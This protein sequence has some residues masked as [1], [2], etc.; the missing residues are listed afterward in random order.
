MTQPNPDGV[1]GTEDVTQSGGPAEDGSGSTG[2]TTGTDTATAQPAGKTYTQA[3]MDAMRARMVAA[4]QNRSKAESA[5]QQLRDKDLPEM[6]KLKRDLEMNATRANEAEQAL[7]EA[8]KENAFFANTKYDWQNPKAALQLLDK[9][10]LDFDADGT[11][12]GMD[13]AIEALAKSDPYLLKPKTEAKEEPKPGTVPGTNGG[14]KA[15]PSATQ[16]SKRFPVMG[17]RIRS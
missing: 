16:L 5:L 1:S 3:E 11:V 2:D 4:D 10:K 13:D 17:T 6:E 7:R 12:T 9:T 14:T 8:R 15:T